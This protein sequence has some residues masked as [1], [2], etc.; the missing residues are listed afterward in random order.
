M[1]IFKLRVT[2]GDAQIELEGN[3]ELVHTIFQELR[4]NGLGK[5]TLHYSQSTNNSNVALPTSV[6]ENV[7]PKEDPIIS[8]E[9]TDGSLPTLENIVLM[10]GPKTEAEWLLVYATYCSNQGKTLFT[11][12]DLKKKYNETNRMTSARSKNFVTNLKTLVADKYIV[13]VNADSF[14]LE[15]AGL[16]KATAIILGNGKNSDTKKNKSTQKKKPI[17]S[18]TMV[19]LDLTEEQR[20]SIKESWNQHTHVSNMDKAVL[21]SYLIRK[22]KQIEAFTPDIFFT[23]LRIVGEGTSFDLAAAIRNAKKDKS[24][25]TSGANVGEYKLNHIGEDYVITLAKTGDNT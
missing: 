7:S 17:A 22:E 9:D 25:F 10:G 19:D 1:D 18:Y 24:Y 3:G 5:L 12:D 13:A 11:R 4:D 15:S 8:T 16:S 6:N 23:I 14:R 20:I 21:A 2:V